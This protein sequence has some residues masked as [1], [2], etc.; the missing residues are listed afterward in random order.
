VDINDPTTVSDTDIE[1]LA[2]EAAEA[3]DLEMVTTCQAAL[4]GDRA[5]RQ[6]VITLILCV[7]EEVSRGR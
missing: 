2:V 1:Q 4:D 7:R 6:E 5:A 3:G